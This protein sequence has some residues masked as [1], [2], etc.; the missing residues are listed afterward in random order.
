MATM[1]HDAM[2]KAIGL[3]TEFDEK[4]AE[5]VDYLE[6]KV[7]TYEDQ[8]GTYLMQINA[9]HLG[10]KDSHTLSVLLHC[11]TDYERIS[12]HALNIMQKARGMS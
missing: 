12:D 5:E 10:N 6:R 4:E 3:L 7:D 1:S 8:L 9:H 11:I 2:A